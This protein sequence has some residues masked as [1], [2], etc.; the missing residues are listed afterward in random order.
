MRSLLGLI[1]A[2]SISLL[3]ACQHF[4]PRD[5][6]RQEKIL[7]F[8]IINSDT[9]ALIPNA[10]CTIVTDTEDS[11]STQLNPDALLLT[12]DYKT[13][14]IDCHAPGY[15][16]HA[17]AITNTLHH[18]SANDLF[19]L[20]PG[21]IVDITSSLFPYYPSHILVLMN[22][23]P[24]VSEKT[25]ERHYQHTKTNNTLYQGTV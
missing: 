18:W 5:T 13:L 2:L 22:K 4:D 19:I 25:M 20:P 23:K 9:F 15:T 12:A 3:T 6:V 17:I 10:H 21:N 14:S 7:N 24:F 11:L 16:Q 8:A 1:I